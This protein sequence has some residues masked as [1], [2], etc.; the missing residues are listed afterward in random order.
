L[1]QSPDLHRS[2][3]NLKQ[4]GK[5]LSLQN[6]L[7]LPPGSVLLLFAS[8]RHRDGAGTLGKQLRAHPR[9]RQAEE[10]GK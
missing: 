1:E 8:P 10:I 2:L 7:G 5:E 3:I 9:S 4:V 6:T